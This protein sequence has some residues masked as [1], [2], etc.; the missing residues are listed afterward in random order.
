MQPP[1]QEKLL[2]EEVR[3]VA[4]TQLRKLSDWKAQS[5]QVLSDFEKQNNAGK[6]AEQGQQELQPLSL[7]YDAAELKVLLQQ[8][9]TT[10]KVV[11]T[12]LPKAEP[13]KRAAEGA[14]TGPSKRLRA[15]GAVGGA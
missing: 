4:E 10:A 3:R 14:N 11:K 6:T 12:A 2:S 5:Q 9:A 1:R 7:P 15:K 8:V 13:K